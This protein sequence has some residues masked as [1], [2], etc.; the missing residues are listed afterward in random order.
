MPSYSPSIVNNATP[1]LIVTSNDVT[2]DQ[3]LN[4]LGPW[5][6]AIENIYQSTTT[7]QQLL[8]RYFFQ[9]YDSDGNQEKNN[10][11][12][13]PDPFQAM[14]SYVQDVD[15]DKIIIN[16]RSSFSFNVLP[17]ETIHLTLYCKM[18]S[19]S[20]MLNKLHPDNFE[21]IKEFFGQYTDKI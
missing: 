12:F 2:Y 15:P 14:N 4:T 5:V 20:E 3:I 7:F 13:T 17:Y 19:S 16:G 8:E 6:Y 21:W 18:M 9:K 10:I 11:V 1:F